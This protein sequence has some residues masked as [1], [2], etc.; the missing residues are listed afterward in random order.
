MAT[1]TPSYRTGWRDHG[2]R[3]G[4]LPGPGTGAGESG[5]ERGLVVYEDRGATASWGWGTATGDA[6]PSSRPPTTRTRRWVTPC[7][8]RADPGRRSGPGAEGQVVLLPVGSPKPWGACCW[9]PARTR[10]RWRRWRRLRRVRPL[11]GRIRLVRELQVP[12]RAPVA[13]SGAPHHHRQQ[14]AGPGGAHRLDATTSSWPTTGR[15]SSSPRSSGDSEGRRRAVQLNNLLFSSFLTQSVI[16]TRQAKPRELNLVDP[17]DGSDLLFEV[18]PTPM[19]AGG[20]RWRLPL[21]PAEHHRPEAGGDG[22]GGPVPALPDRRG[23]G[24][25]GVGAAERHARE[26]GRPHPGDRRPLEHH[27]DEPGG[28]RLFECP[29]RGARGVQPPAGVCGRTTPSSPA[30]MSDFLLRPRS[31]GWRRSSCRT[32]IRGRVPRGGGEQQ[33]P[34]R[35]GEPTAIVSVIHDLTQVVENERLARELRS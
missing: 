2:T 31:G 30:L 1:A 11:S 29:G 4:P 25:G 15:T 35:R 8:G 34:E 6:V 19:P 24:A 32:R 10:P 14:P 33:D 3:R 22:A 16:S 23:A 5:L 20:E 12:G 21:D 18:L 7:A 13:T 9:T 28:E 26:R 17:S 27:P